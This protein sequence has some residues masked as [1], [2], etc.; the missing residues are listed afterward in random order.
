MD[1]PLGR[2]GLMYYYDVI[3]I[4]SI[5]PLG[6]L[7]MC[8]L[9]EAGK[10]GYRVVGI[11]KIDDMRPGILIEMAYTKG[12]PQGNWKEQPLIPHPI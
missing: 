9:E 11:C 10:R 4:S 1:D 6:E 3:E 12:K 5:E 7:D 8:D 2:P